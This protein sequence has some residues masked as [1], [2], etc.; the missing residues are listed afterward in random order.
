MKKF[1]VYYCGSWNHGF[2]KT[3]QAENQQQAEQMFQDWFNQ[4]TNWITACGD[5]YY[6]EFAWREL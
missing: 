2:E 3:F 6:A 1:L 4:G 5:D